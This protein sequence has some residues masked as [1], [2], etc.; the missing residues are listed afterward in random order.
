MTL[1]LRSAADGEGVPLV[2]GDGRDVQVDVVS[3]LVV[4]KLRSLDHEVSHLEEE[5]TREAVSIQRAPHAGR[6]LLGWSSRSPQACGFVSPVVESSQHESQHYGFHL[7]KGL[8]SCSLPG[9]AVKQRSQLGLASSKNFFE[10]TKSQSS[11]HFVFFC[12]KFRV[13]FT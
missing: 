9:F 13:F 5:E 6:S 12:F 7:R 4:E 11:F 1:L 2:G 10:E 8:F 3:G